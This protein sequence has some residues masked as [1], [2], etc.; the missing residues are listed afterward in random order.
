MKTL[1]SVLN[2]L[3][4]PLRII[5]ISWNPE[6]LYS[7]IAVG[8][9]ELRFKPSLSNDSNFCKKKCHTIEKCYKR[10][11]KHKLSN[12]N[13]FRKSVQ[14]SNTTLM[15]SSYQNPNQSSYSPHNSKEQN[16]SNYQNKNKAIP[17]IHNAILIYSYCKNSYHSNKL[18]LL[19]MR[20]EVSVLKIPKYRTILNLKFHTSRKTAMVPNIIS[21]LFGITIGICKFNFFWILSSKCFRCKKFFDKLIIR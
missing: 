1:D 11:N 12:Q 9:A 17:N 16:Y 3:Y 2:E 6:D 13:N 15:S 4:E 20:V 5:I 14:N 18:I 7:T 10:Q 8:V 21:Q 19:I